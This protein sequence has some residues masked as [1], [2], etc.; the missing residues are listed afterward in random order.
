MFSPVICR[1]V[2]RQRSFS[3]TTA[4]RNL[5]GNS[6]VQLKLQMGGNVKHHVCDSLKLSAVRRKAEEQQRGEENGGSG[7]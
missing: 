7:Y 6:C 3:I 5:F 2:Y 4:L 1:V